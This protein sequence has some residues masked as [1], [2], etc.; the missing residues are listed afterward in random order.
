[1]AMKY[2]VSAY[3][4]FFFLTDSCLTSVSFV[5]REALV[6]G[7]VRTIQKL[8]ASMNI[9]V[10]TLAFHALVALVFDTAFNLANSSFQPVMI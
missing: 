2:S 5:T 10:E 4:L 9:L 8:A 7:P 3:E 6:T 1:M